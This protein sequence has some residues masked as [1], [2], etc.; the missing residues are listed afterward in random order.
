VSAGGTWTVTHNLGS[1][2]ILAQVARVASPYDLVDVRI[3]RT[4]S[5]TLS[6]LPDVALSSGDYE[7]MVQKVA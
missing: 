6:V 3:E 1:K 4:T 7:I 2:F 5:N